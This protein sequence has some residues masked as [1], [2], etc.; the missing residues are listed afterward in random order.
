MQTKEYPQLNETLY[1]E[2]LENGLQVVLLP[3]P[4]FNKTYALFGTDFGSIDQ[5]FT[6]IGQSEP[7]NF[8]DGIAHFLEHKMFEKEDGDIF[9]EFSKY[10]AAANA[11]TSFT[12]TAYLF[13]TTHF[14][15][16]NIKTLLDF[17]QAPY[18]TEETVEKEKGIIAQEIGMYEDEASFQLMMGILQNLY[19]DHPVH[20]DILGTVE[21]I[22]QI[23]A[24]MLYDNYNT[25]YHP[26]NM[27]LLVVGQIE[28]EETMALIRANQEA[29]DFPEAPIPNRIFP[30]ENL[31]EIT[32]E[33]TIYMPI[34]KP[35]VSLG[36]RGLQTDLT[37]EDALRYEI[38]MSLYMEMLLGPTSE[39]YLSLYDEGIIDDSYS[40]EFLFE[41]T[42]NTINVSTD[43]KQP[44]EFKKRMKAILL[45]HQASA[46]INPEHFELI[47]RKTIGKVLQALNSL[48]YIAYQ[49]MSKS[50]GEATVFDFVPFLEEMTLE[51]TIEVANDYIR[52]E[53]LSVFTILPEES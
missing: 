18:F 22:N 14:V 11:F 36:I 5:H 48:E 25:F 6:P 51:E 1:T 52:E 26:S 4:D 23:T 8:P 49:F 46:D 3:K 17:V 12:R 32:A 30:E 44:E 28:P 39:T 20:I 10:G 7:V 27:T 53:L 16:E 50:Y 38:A 31:D 40:T 21:S 15:E 24:D 41:R 29:K 47:K 33:K 19:P 35:K 2:T 42:F 37:G 9:H 45:D 34:Q 43:T 13:S